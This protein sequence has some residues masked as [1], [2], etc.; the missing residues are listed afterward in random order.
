MSGIKGLMRSG[1]S[2]RFGPT[3]ASLPGTDTH[4]PIRALTEAPPGC[5]ALVPGP[6]VGGLL[7]ATSRRSVPARQAEVPARRADKRRSLMEPL[8]QDCQIP[9][10]ALALS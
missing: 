1:L 8:S 2:Q 9:R 3:S 7:K 6:S 4:G 5:I 10:S